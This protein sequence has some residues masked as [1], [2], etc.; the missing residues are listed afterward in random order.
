MNNRPFLYYFTSFLLTF[1][2]GMCLLCESAHGQEGKTQFE[3]MRSELWSGS[4]PLVNLTV[5]IS[6]V[7]TGT[8]VNGEIEVVD[9][10]KRTDPS[11]ESVKCRC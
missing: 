3:Q 7:N 8:F 9:F 5:D 4:L 10:H 11:A 1:V 2:L 6:A